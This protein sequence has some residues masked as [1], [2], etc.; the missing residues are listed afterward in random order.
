VGWYVAWV[1]LA[2]AAQ[3][4]RARGAPRAAVAELAVGRAGPLRLLPYAAVLVGYALLLAVTAGEWDEQ[5]YGVLLGAV[6]LTALLIGRQ[7]LTLSDNL[8]LYRRAQQEIAERQAAEAALRESETRYRELVTLLPGAV[9]T[10]ATDE[11]G[12]PL[13]WSPQFEQLLGYTPQEALD[14]P[15]LW[16]K[17]THPDDRERLVR[18][19]RAGM[20]S[21]GS[22]RSEYRVVTRDG[23]IRWFSDEA[24]VL[25]TGAGVPD[26]VF[27]IVLDVTA[28]IEA[29]QALRESEQHFRAIFEGG[30]LG[31]ALV[32]PQG[33]VAAANP[34]LCRLLGRSEDELRGA[35]LTDVLHPDDAPTHSALLRDALEGRHERY[36][37]D[38]RLIRADGAAV[39]GRLSC[40]LLRDEQSRPRHLV[41]LV[42]DVTEATRHARRREALLRASRLLAAAPDPDA[43]LE[44]LLREGRA[45]LDSEIG[46]V[47]RWDADDAAFIVVATSP[48]S[49]PTRR[50]TPLG[51]GAIGRAAQQRRAVIMN[52]YQHAPDRNPALAAAGAQA[53]IGVALF[54][55]ERLLGAL[56]LATTTPGRRYDREDGEALEVLAGLAAAALAGYE[57]ERAEARFR[58]LVERS[59]DIIVVLDPR[60][61]I[62]YESPANVRILG[63]AAADLPDRDAFAGVHPDDLEPVRAAF[64]S[65]VVSGGTSPLVTFRYRH[66]DGAWRTLEGVATNLL[67]DP[68]VGGIVVNARDV[69]ERVQAEEAVREREARLRAIF[70]G[71]SIGIALGDSHGRPV[72]CNPAFARMLGYAPEELRQIPFAQF[73]HPDDVVTSLALFRELRD[74]ARDRYQITKRYLRKDGSV[75]WGT[76][77]AAAL[78]LPEGLSPYTLVM[79]EDVT[80]AVRSRE[81]REALLRL[82][83]RFA[84]ET[85]SEQL[86]SDLLAEGPAVVDGDGAMVMRW[87][88]ER[89]GLV[90]VRNSVTTGEITEVVSLGKGAVG[91]A[92]ERRAPVVLN[93]YQR[94]AD[95]PAWVLRAGVQAVVAAPLLHEGRLVGA[96]G[97][98]TTDPAH[99]FGPEDA[100]ALEVLAGIAASVLVGLEAAETDALT[101]LAIRRKGREVLERLLA[102]ARRQGRPLALAMMDLDHFKTVNDT[103][104][105]DRGDEVLRRFGRTLRGAFREADVVA[106]WGGEE[107]LVALYESPRSA[108]GARLDALLECFR[109]ETFAT[110]DGTTFGVTFSGGVAE[111]PADAQDLDTLIRAA[112]QALY[113]AK[114]RGRARV[115]LAEAPAS[116]VLQADNAAP[117]ANGA[118]TK[119][120][121]RRGAADGGER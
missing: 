51:V 119:R 67:D 11:L 83:R 18:E 110:A 85:D 43:M 80:E 72:Q 115:E 77:T 28:R 58:A 8:R 102:L 99:R 94:R 97:V 91:E 62:T 79:I 30:P 20:K 49:S 92:A 71:A 2:A 41:V 104:G 54:H 107:F 15:E 1:A 76:L 60:G 75:L 66:A 50:R 32:E 13:Y 109:Q 61:R 37:L 59:S 82:A 108:C 86:L 23:R 89:G 6:L 68:G 24:R 111:F 9:Y 90:V 10:T 73:T 47:Y 112:D 78:R 65:V 63:I 105:H 70:D 7:T 116:P 106:R 98:S 16:I 74:G 31:A 42:E 87:E 26:R 57:L 17:T 45:M 120:V 52:D 118:H 69:T 44:T 21:G 34:G 35:T 29:E 27:G 95:V 25:H 93:D 117:A 46:T 22:F 3:V 81:R 103:Y 56:A 38:A 36:Q 88:A 48:E 121:R 5:D 12:T 100:E 84:A 96:F 14:D 113:R 55:E 101:E 114:E 53:G 19:F 4:Q 33:R 64:S 40:A 39:L